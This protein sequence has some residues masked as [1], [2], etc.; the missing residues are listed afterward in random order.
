MARTSCRV[1]CETLVTT[2]LAFMAGEIT[3]DCYVDIP[4]I[5]RETIKDI[6]YSSSQMGFRLADLLGDHQHRPAV[7]RISPR[8]STRARAL[9]KDQGAGDQGLM[10]GFATDE[11]P[12]LMPMPIMYAHKLT[13]RLA[14]CAKTARW[15][16]CARTAN[17]R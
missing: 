3:T 17:P 14:R 5:V 6:G 16:S 8:G 4:Q 2:G 7:R 11:T 9:Y 13:R 12:E 10:F 1:A 15:I